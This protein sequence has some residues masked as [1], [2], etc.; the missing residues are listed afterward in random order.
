MK[1]APNFQWQKYEGTEEN[2]K[3]QFQ[4]QLQ[5]QYDQISNAVN[6]TVDDISY[7]LKERPTGLTW[8]DGTQIF[9]QTYTGTLGAGANTIPHGIVGLSTLIEAN[10]TTQDAV[11][12]AISGI[13]LPYIDP[14][15]LA[16]GIGLL[17]TPTNIVIT[18]ANGTWV[19]YIYNVNLKYT[20]VRVT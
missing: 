20:K 19:G 16:N 18:L 8:K 2:Q 1:L 3:Y 9:T 4:F 7:W 5:K 11:T 12:M 6:T 14:T 17:V 13:P 15:T 10:G